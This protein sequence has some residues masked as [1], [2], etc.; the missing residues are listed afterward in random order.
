[1]VTDRDLKWVL[2]RQTL[3]ELKLT[4]FSSYLF[5]LRLKGK[6]DLIIDSLLLVHGGERA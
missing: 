2:Y 3:I 1:M 6:S 4:S 5:N